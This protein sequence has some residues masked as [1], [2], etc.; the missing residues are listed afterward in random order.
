MVFLL[1]VISGCDRSGHKTDSMLYREAAFDEAR[2]PTEK[3]L[4]L[5]TIEVKQAPRDHLDT[6]IVINSAI[7]DAIKIYRNK[8]INNW[9]DPQLSKLQQ[10]MLDLQPQLA[11]IAVELL[12]Q[13]NQRTRLLRTQ[14]EQVKTLPMGAQNNSSADK[15]SYLAEKYNEELEECCLIALGRIEE[16]LKRASKDYRPL[17]MVIRSIHAKLEQVIR[18]ETYGAILRNEIN[19]LG[20]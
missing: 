1:V 16:L 12:H 6:L 11:S 3:A 15:V 13:S 8:N 20:H 9:E 18:E 10:E 4:A 19:T 7:R 14:L 17:V 5:F 2:K